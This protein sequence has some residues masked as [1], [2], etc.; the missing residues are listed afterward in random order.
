[1]N[2]THEDKIVIFITI[3]ALRPDHLNSYGYHRIT[4][5]HLDNFIRHGTKF[6]K[7]FTNGP[8]TPSSF[9]AMFSSILPY[10][11]GGYSP[12]PLEKLTFPQILQE[13]K[14]HT[15]GI[16]SNPN[17]SKY[18]NYG[19][20]FEIFLDGERFKERKTVKKAGS[21]KSTLYSL[22]RKIFNF[23]NLF[24]KIIFNIPFFNKMKSYLRDKVPKIT[25]LLLP[26]TPMAYNAP[27]IVN[28]VIDL[29]KKNKAPLFLWMHFMDIHSPYNP[30]AKFVLRFRKKDF[31]LFERKFLIE[32]IYPNKAQDSV[33]QKNIEDLKV[34]YDAEISYVDDSLKVL[35][36]F[37]KKN[38]NQNCLVIITSDHG[39]SF[40]EHGIFGHQGSIYDE[41]LKIPLFIREM[42]ED[43]NP[44]VCKNFVQ[45]IDIAPTILNYFNLDIPEDF[46][47][48]NLY[49][50]L[51]GVDLERKELLITECYQK[52]GFLKRNNIEGFKLVSI[53]SDDWK[54]ILDEEKGSE[55]FFNLKNDPGEKIN[56]IDVNKK[57]LL[58][59]RLIKDYHYQKISEKDEKSRIV[60]KL[61]NLKI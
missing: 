60:D 42:G 13:N 57:E 24:N 17:L 43:K 16:H 9:S 39:E 41:L 52:G 59:F 31:T 32:H 12:L 11:S 25:D 30:P 55:F 22:I 26:F 53:R 45:L 37:I 6:T 34:L 35:F 8:E 44:K 48:I 2:T 56:L 15:F 3:D 20:G 33:T 14:I 28:K 21:T 47:G 27:Y 18:F 58:N 5:P 19:R 51:Q 40:Y 29:L 10:L 4:A 46:Q 7:T 54:Y 49:P 50:I 36:S 1:M 23:K 61:K 38:L